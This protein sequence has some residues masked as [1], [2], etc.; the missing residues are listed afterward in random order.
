M[1][2]PPLVR[3]RVARERQSETVPFQ[4]EAGCPF[5]MNRREASDYHTVFLVYDIVDLRPVVLCN[6]EFKRCGVDGTSQRTVHPGPRLLHV[7]HRS[8]EA[9]LLAH[10]A[11]SR[12]PYTQGNRTVVLRAGHVECC[13]ISHVIHM[14]MRDKDLVQIVQ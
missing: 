10:A 4:D 14:W 11:T 12:A 2:Y 3:E 5:E 8:L 13:Q 6:F 7:I 1:L 9:P